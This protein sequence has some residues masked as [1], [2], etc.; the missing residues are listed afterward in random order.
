MKSVRIKAGSSC[1]VFPAATAC[2]RTRMSALVLLSAVMMN[3]CG[4][5]DLITDNTYKRAISSGPFDAI[6]VPG[7]AFDSVMANRIFRAR[8][9]WAISLYEKG[10]A[11][12]I[13]FS[14]AAVYT[15]FVEGLTMKIIADSLGVPPDYTFF[16]TRAQHSTENIDYGL[17][18]ADSLDFKN[19]AIATDPMQA[20][21]VNHYLK[22]KNR[23][24]PVLSFE[25]DS[26]IPYNRPLPMV[27]AQVAFVENFVP[28][29]QREQEERIMARK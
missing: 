26:M 7:N 8:I 11:R 12:N 13:I 27:N 4:V 2:S 3:S 20:I 6:I 19:V 18:L 15:P 21:Y 16:E 23:R 25:L 29:K 24:M 9:Y 1:C 22:Q 17:Q 5:I 28:L 10:I 14:G